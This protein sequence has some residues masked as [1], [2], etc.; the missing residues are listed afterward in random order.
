MPRVPE[1]DSLQVG[2]NA[3][4]PTP[5]HATPLQ[6]IGAQHA[7]QLRHAQGGVGQLAGD[8]A[9]INAQVQQ[10]E[11]AAKADANKVRVNDALNAVVRQ[12]HFLTYDKDAGFVNRKGEDV[13]KAGEKTGVSFVEQYSKDFDEFVTGIAKG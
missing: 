4:S 5:I 9:R 7:Q 2:Q 3:L 11:A 6:D 13:V 1:Y 12:Q 8:A 10:I